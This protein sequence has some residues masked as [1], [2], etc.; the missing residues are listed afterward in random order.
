[1]QPGVGFATS[2]EIPYATASGT[3]VNATTARALG[4]DL[5][6]ALKQNLADPGH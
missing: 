5:A 2:L 4:R 6:M 1:M 3:E